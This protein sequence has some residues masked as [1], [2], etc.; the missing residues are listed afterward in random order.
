MIYAYLFISKG[1][2]KNC[3][4]SLDSGVLVKFVWAYV[5]SIEYLKYDFNFAAEVQRLILE[6]LPCRKNAEEFQSR[7]NSNLCFLIS[8]KY[9]FNWEEMK[10]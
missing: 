9:S 6:F 4:I 3:N 5:V 8:I 2:W 1:L 10:T 7:F